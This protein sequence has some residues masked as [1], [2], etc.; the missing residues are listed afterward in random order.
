MRRFSSCTHLYEWPLSCS[1]KEAS[2]A[3]ERLVAIAGCGSPG[4]WAAPGDVLTTSAST[5][6]NQRLRREASPA[7]LGKRFTRTARRLERMGALYRRPAAS[8]V[9][10]H[11]C[12]GT[13]W[14]WA[15]M[16]ACWRPT[17]YD[18]RTGCT[19]HAILRRALRKRRP[20]WLVRADRRL[21]SKHLRCTAAGLLRMLR[22]SSAARFLRRALSCTSP[23]LLRDAAGQEMLSCWGE[24]SIERLGAISALRTAP[25]RLG[26]TAPSAVVCA[27]VLERLPIVMPPRPAWET[28]YQVRAQAPY[29]HASRC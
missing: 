13:A 16:H 29:R 3:Y 15:C 10:R 14:R 18:E 21:V 9:M 7:V 24:A 27:C 8:S 26:T 25:R 23:P 20:A 11:S 28:E 1:I 12:T 5:V 2:S 17:L 6:Q 22:A 4:A 19:A